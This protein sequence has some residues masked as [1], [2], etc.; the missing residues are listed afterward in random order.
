MS[1]IKR[2]NYKTS[3]RKE[4]RWS[5]LLFETIEFSTCR[6]LTIEIFATMEIYVYVVFGVVSLL[7][8]SFKYSTQIFD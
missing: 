8:K 5:R 4:E 1:E 2:G 6:L 7:I 3:I